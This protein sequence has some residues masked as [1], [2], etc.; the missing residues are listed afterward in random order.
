MATHGVI[1]DVDGVLVDSYDAHFRSWRDVL[2][3]HGL[4]MTEDAF[5]KT[6]GRTSREIIA[7]FW[8]DDVDPTRA[9]EIDD[10]KEALYRELIAE[11]FPA[12]AGAAE[13][14]DALVAAGFALAVGSSAPPENVL[15]TLDAL[16]RREAFAA[17]VTGRDVTR[18]KPDPQVFQIAAERLALPPARCAVIEDAPAGVRAAVTA[19]AACIALVGT[20]PR[21]ALADAGA[22]ATVASLRELTPDA[23]A[24]LIDDR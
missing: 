17:M 10:R 13:L 3:E 22:H 15:L 19:G 1:F 8:G 12:M 7:K 5:A 4:D 6:F 9:R 18:G 23:I 24:R 21:E 20:A 14:I 2:A 16:G 11:R